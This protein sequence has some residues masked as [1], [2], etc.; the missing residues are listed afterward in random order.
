MAT[1]ER[2]KKRREDK[3]KQTQPTEE[4]MDCGHFD[5]HVQEKKIK[6]K[7]IILKIIISWSFLSFL[8][9]NILH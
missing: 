9:G 5:F 7:K 6:F 2:W 4:Q 3:S 1:E 8:Y